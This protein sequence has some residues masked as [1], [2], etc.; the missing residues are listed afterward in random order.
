MIGKNLVTILVATIIG[1]LFALQSAH[2][3]KVVSN[4][5]DQGS[6]IVQHQQTIVDSTYRIAHHSKV[7]VVESLVI[8][9][10]SVNMALDMA[11]EAL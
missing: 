4:F 8:T 11:I 7:I 2:A 10:N 1:T 6:I 9:K 5:T 3:N